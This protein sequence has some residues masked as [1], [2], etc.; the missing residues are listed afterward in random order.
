MRRP[1]LMTFVLAQMV[2]ATMLPTVSASGQTFPSRSIRI[3]VPFPPGGAA[4]VSARLIAQRLSEV[5]GRPAV[6]ENRTGASGTI[7]VDTVVRS[8][9][10]GHT[11]LITTGDFITVPA[12]MFPAMSFDPLKALLP[13]MRV[14]TAPLVLLGHAGAPFADAREMVAAAK[15]SPGKYAFSS[16][17]LG[18]IN[19][20]AVEWLAI[21]TG[22]KLLHVPYR[23]GTPAVTAIAAGEVQLGV[24]T[25]SSALTAVQSGRVR[26]LGLMIKEKPAFVADIRPLAEQGLPAIDASLFIGLYAPANTPPEIAERLARE[27]TKI[28]EDEALRKRLNGIGAEATPLAGQAF[29]DFIVS[30]GERYARVIREAGI[31]PSR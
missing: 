14:A 3:I 1:L 5:L 4:D 15:A 10:D 2:L 6:V 8:D 22:I 30:T 28:L 19:H 16:P 13:I 24:V 27:V 25:L 31:K 23:G 20:L 21:D 9:P 12:E 17:G 29:K 18:T 7:G 11:L 26:T